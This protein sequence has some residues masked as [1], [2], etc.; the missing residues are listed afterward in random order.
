MMCLPPKSGSVLA[1]GAVV[2]AG[3]EVAAGAQAAD[4]N[5]KTIVTINI[6]QAFILFSFGIFKK[7][8]KK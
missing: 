8:G 3:V 5:A 2:A 4:K 1:G 6:W 7:H